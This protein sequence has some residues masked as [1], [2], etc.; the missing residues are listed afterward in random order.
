MNVEFTRTQNLNLEADADAIH[1]WRLLGWEVAS[2]DGKEIVGICDECS[3]PIMDVKDL[4][5]QGEDAP[6]SCVKCVPRF[7]WRDILGRILK[8]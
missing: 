1:R 6:M 7:V 3:R 8:P 2:V 5:N 4:L